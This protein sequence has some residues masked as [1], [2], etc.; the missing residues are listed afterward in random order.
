MTVRFSRTLAPTVLARRAARLIRQSRLTVALT[1]AG[2]STPSGLPDFRSP[3]TGLWNT[4]HIDPMRVGSLRGFCAD[5]QAFYDW[6]RPLARMMLQAVPNPAHL[7]LADLEGRDYLQAV[8]TQN[9]DLLHSRAG[10][11]KVLE[12]HGQIREATCLRCYQVQPAWPI[13]ARFVEDGRTPR[14]PRQACG[15]VL[16]PNVIL[17]G[18]QLPAA[19]LVE[20]QRLARRC[21]LMIVA[22]S[23]LDVAPAGDLPVLALAAGARLLILNREPTPLDGEA[24][25]VIHADVAEALPAVWTEV[26]ALEVHGE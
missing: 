1:G 20:A 8:I 4:A 3:G 2:I 16:K 26:L 15:G 7:A 17:Y 21:D 11:K 9:I 23:S 6:I 25:V 14:C 19:V 13:M 5:P 10:S 24:D 12:I 22:G 18:E